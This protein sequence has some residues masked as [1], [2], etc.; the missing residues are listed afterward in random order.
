[1]KTI[2]RLIY[3]LLFLFI[4]LPMLYFL[5]AIVL[6]SI[7]VN[8]DQGNTLENKT[9]TIYLSTNGV[10][11]DIILKADNLST[12]LKNGLLGEAKYYGFGWGEENFYLNTPTWGDLTFKNGFRALFLPSD[13]L[14]HIKRINAPESDWLAV[15]LSQNK[16]NKLN[17]QLETKFA[18]NEAGKKIHLPDTGYTK[19]DDFYRANGSYTLFYTCNTW[20][21]DVFKASGLKASYWTP[22]D[23]G[24]LGKWENE[25]P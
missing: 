3:T 22:F 10:H 2:K 24:L 18:T 14:M 6:G 21:N 8:N 19:T 17:K 9:E 23:F 12:G 1:M 11:L 13:S 5:S 25:Q 20:A 7:T 16:L 15:P 4:G